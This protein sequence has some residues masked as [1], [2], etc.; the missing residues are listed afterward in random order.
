MIMVYA[1]YNTQGCFF[2]D[3]EA[4]SIKEARKLFAEKFYGEFTILDENGNVKRV[5]L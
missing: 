2:E 3:V 4:D 5:K 1:L